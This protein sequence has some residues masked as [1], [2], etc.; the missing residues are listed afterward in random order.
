MADGGLVTGDAGGGA[1][2]AVT[3]EGACA[4]MEGALLAQTVATVLTR[5]E[6]R[7]SRVEWKLDKLLAAGSAARAAGV[8]QCGRLDY[9]P[10]FED[11]WVDGEHFDLRERA[12]ARCCLQ[13]LVEQQA[14]TRESARH[15]AGESDAYVWGRT[16]LPASAEIKIDHYFQD[17]R[18]KLPRLCQ[19]VV[20]G[21]ERN[22]RFYPAVKV[23]APF[24][25]V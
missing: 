4:T 24:D 12:K 21:A 20:R 15:L 19:A 11:V 5:L 17:H 18:G 2:G 8:M 22:G 1:C 6:E 16:G 23:R 13:Y 9:R 25:P 10:G 7:L 14:F 3:G